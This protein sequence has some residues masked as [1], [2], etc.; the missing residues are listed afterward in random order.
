MHI[1]KSD[2][3]CNIV[4]KMKICSSFRFLSWKYT[5]F[6]IFRVLS[7]LL[8][9]TWHCII[10]AD[11]DWLNKILNIWFNPRSSHRLMLWSSRCRYEHVEN[12]LYLLQPGLHCLKRDWLDMNLNLRSNETC[13]SKRNNLIRLGNALSTHISSCRHGVFLYL[14]CMKWKEF[15]YNDLWIALTETWQSLLIGRL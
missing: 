14:I 11:W 7:C 8:P 12:M 3:G 5:F 2:E 13:A 6:Y 1:R 15:E 10:V 9:F 4:T